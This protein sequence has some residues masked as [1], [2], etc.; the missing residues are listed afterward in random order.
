MALNNL[1]I[2]DPLV[3]VPMPPQAPFREDYA[4]LPTGI[5]WYRD[6]GGAGEPIVFLHPAASGDPVLWGYQQPFFVNAGYRVIAYARRGY[7]KSDRISTAHPG[8]AAEDLHHFIQALGLG[9]V[10]LVSSGA[11]GSVA[12]DFALT[13]TDQLRSLCVSSNYSGVRRGHIYN[14]AQLIRV[15]QWNELPRWYREFSPSYIIAN[16]PGL[17]AWMA[18]QDESSKAKGLDQEGYN[19]IEAPMFE[20]MTAPTLLLTG[21]ADTSTPPSLMR[22]LARHFPNVELSIVAECGHSPYWERP[23]VFNE[24]LLA[25]IQKHAG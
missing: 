1:K 14:S 4:Q 9:R 12:G 8:N 3:P 13:H 2:D 15:K 24:T 10:H 19:D 17:K 6:S 20:T 16:Q 18:I 22:M 23:Q 7:H 11:G 5:L 21:D 25:F